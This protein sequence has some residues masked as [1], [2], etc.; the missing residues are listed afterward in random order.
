MRTERSKIQT[1]RR[2]RQI[3][4]NNM[5]TERSKIRTVR[6]K[7]QVRRNNIQNISNKWQA[8]KQK[9]AGKLAAAAGSVGPGHCSPQSSKQY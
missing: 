6:R 1:V 5:R 9:L 7:R 8:R 4:R 3:R 2:K